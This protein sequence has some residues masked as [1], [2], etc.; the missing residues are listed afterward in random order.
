MSTNPVPEV[1]WTLREPGHT[2]TQTAPA[3][4]GL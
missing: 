1:T 3:H 2:V 4:W